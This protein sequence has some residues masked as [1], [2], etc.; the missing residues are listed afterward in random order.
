MKQI[1]EKNAYI[2]ETLYRRYE[3]ETNRRIT[4]EIRQRIII[5]AQ[6]LGAGNP[7]H[8]LK[9]ITGEVYNSKT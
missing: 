6:Q 3:L 8:I 2:C 9:I 4:K 5:E 1:A 7:L